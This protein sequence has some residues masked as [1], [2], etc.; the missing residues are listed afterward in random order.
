MPVLQNSVFGYLV[1]G[2]INAFNIKQHSFVV[3][4]D[5]SAENQVQFDLQKFWTLE[6]LRTPT[7][8]FLVLK[9]NKRQ[10]NVVKKYR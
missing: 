4:H 8:A 6:E 3:S 7:I 1:T 2:Q 9:R 5:L 10:S